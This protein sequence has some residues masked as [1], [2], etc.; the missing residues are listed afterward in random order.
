MQLCAPFLFS[1]FFA[2]L[3]LIGCA[4]HSHVIS[5]DFGSIEAPTNGQLAVLKLKSG[6]EVIAR[7]L[8][9]EDDT[10]FAQIL[11]FSISPIPIDSVS[12]IRI[13]QRG[14]HGRES[15]DVKPGAIAKEV[16]SS[17]V[18]F[19]AAIWLVVVLPALIL[20]WLVSDYVGS[21]KGK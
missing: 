11:D 14:E 7:K 6:E 5:G 8:Q 18:G 3:V 19:Q 10:L 2:A 17:E 9:E 4:S 15:V 13:R 12:E 21:L 20:G 16:A 1:G